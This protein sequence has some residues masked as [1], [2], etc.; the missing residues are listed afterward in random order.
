M[1]SNA[2]KNLLRFFQN[3]CS[4]SE[5]GAIMVDVKSGHHLADW[6]LAMDAYEIECYDDLELP[7]SNVNFDRLLLKIQEK[8]FNREL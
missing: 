4:A 1:E 7:P 3:K 8:I 6:K 5:I 2:S